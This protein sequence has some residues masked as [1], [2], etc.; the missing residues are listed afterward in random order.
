MVQKYEM[1]N[2]RNKQLLSFQPH[3]TE[4]HDEILHH[5]PAH[6]KVNQPS[7]QHIPTVSH[8]VDISVIR[9][10]LMVSKPYF[11][12][13]DPKVQEQRCWQFQYAKEKP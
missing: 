8:W 12:N 2:V 1:E 5:F 4:Q 9:S 7:V 13:N 3:T 6:R 11:I 10:V